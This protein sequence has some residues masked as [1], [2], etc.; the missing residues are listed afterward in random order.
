MAKKGIEYAVFGLL[1]EDK[2]YKDGKYLSP[3][4]GF[5][6][7]P[8]KSNVTDYGDNRALE[9]DNSVTGGTLSVELND[10]N[11]DIYVFLLGHKKDDQSGEIVYNV[12]DRPPLVGCGAIGQSGEKYVGKFYRKVQFGEPNDENSTKQENVTFA[13][14]TIEG[15]I[16]I[17][18][19]GIWKERQTFDTL[20]AAKT[21]L[22]GKAGIKTTVTPEG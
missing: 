7:T 8:T 2:S 1:Q 15:T 9:T 21:W 14:T 16:L 19:D 12:N 13:H 11:D 18:D 6:G 3:V 17:P 22:N 10:D 5:N 4:A 20:E